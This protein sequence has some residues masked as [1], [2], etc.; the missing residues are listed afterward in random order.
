MPTDMVFYVAFNDFSEHARAH[1]AK[2]LRKFLTKQDVHFATSEEVDM[3]DLVALRGVSGA[4]ASALVDTES[5]PPIIDGAFIPL[6]RY[7]EFTNA[8]AELA[9]KVHT[10]LPVRTNMLTNTVTVYP[11]LKL[12]EVSDKQK[13]FRLMNEYSALVEKSGG[14]FVA[15]EG[16]G[17][18]KANAAGERSDEEKPSRTRETREKF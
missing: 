13:I 16:E 8:L 10:P 18:L 1:K 7:E 3:T 15:K 4:V 2:K 9:T 14:T 12:G 11:V 17:R 5:L 6:N